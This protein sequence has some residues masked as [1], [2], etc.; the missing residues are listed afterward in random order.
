MLNDP[1]DQA[2]S[3]LPVSLAIVALSTTCRTNGWNGL[4]VGLARKLVAVRG[5]KTAGKATV[6]LSSASL[7]LFALRSREAL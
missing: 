3:P 2:Q 6:Q 1:R 5:A 7:A 4:G